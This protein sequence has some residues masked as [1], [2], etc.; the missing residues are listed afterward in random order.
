M[1]EKA[2]K[3]FIKDNARPVDLAWYRYCFEEGGASE[4]ITEL[5]KFQNPDGG[6]GH[7]LEADYWNPASTPIATNEAVFRLNQVG[8]LHRN[9]Q[10]VMDIVRYLKSG[11]SFD[12]DKKRW[13]FAL[14]GNRAYPHAVWWVP[15]EG[16]DGIN[17]FN[18]TVSLAAFVVCFG[19]DDGFYADIV[20]EAFEFLEKAEKLDGDSLK[21]FMLSYALLSNTGRNDIIDLANAKLV[22]KKLIYGAICKDVTK[23]GREYVSTPS[24][25][26][27]GRFWDFYSPE[28][29]EMIYAEKNNLFRIQLEDGGFDIYWKWYT[30]YPEFEEARKMWRPKISLEK[31]LFWDSIE[32]KKNKGHEVS[33]DDEPTK[34]GVISLVMSGVTLLLLL[35]GFYS[36]FAVTFLITFVFTIFARVMHPEDTIS[37]ILI[38]I[39]ILGFILMFTLVYLL[40]VA[41][42]DLTGNACNTG[43]DMCRSFPG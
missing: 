34:A 39:L 36:L 12:C 29:E 16:S 31:L 26:F 25:F 19:M 18:P 17:G 40:A 14:E 41:C 37:K 21:C 28:F 22:I 35:T 6:F 7:G 38:W 1:N 11:D 10:I 8:A 42:G 5:K 13:L 20:K 30:D 43:C 27:N 15:E 3:Q 2:V 4:V 33:G 24:D 9:D 32:N 23:Y